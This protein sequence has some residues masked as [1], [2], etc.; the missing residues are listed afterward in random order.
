MVPGETGDALTQQFDDPDTTY[1]VEFIA[2]KD[3]QTK[4][5]S[6]TFTTPTIILDKGNFDIGPVSSNKTL[7]VSLKPNTG[8]T[9]DWTIAWSSSS[10]TYATFS[11]IDAV[12]T[13][14]TFVATGNLTLTFTATSP[15]EK[16]VSWTSPGIYVEPLAE[17][18]LVLTGVPSS[19]VPASDKNVVITTGAN[20]SVGIT[21]PSG[22][23]MAP[24]DKF[25]TVWGKYGLGEAAYNS[26]A[27]PSGSV[28]IGINIILDDEVSGIEPFISN[29]SKVVKPGQYD[30]RNRNTGSSGGYVLIQC[31]SVEYF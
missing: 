19:V 23:K 3:G 12:L 18:D 8:I 27:I 15:N 20:G 4:S 31:I 1:T 6:T 22:T 17:G 14:A 10:D 30:V 5:D 28:N 13:T 29:S 21:C 9:D 24:I 2:A 16:V 26:K 11:S 7:T 25:S